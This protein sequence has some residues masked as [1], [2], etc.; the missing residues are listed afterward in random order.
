MSYQPADGVPQQ[1]GWGWYCDKDRHTLQS[2]LRETPGRGTPAGTRI[3]TS[4]DL[5]TATGKCFK[6][7]F[8]ASQYLIAFKSVALT[9]CRL[10]KLHTFLL[11]LYLW[12]DMQCDVTSLPYHLS[13]RPT[14]TGAED[15]LFTAGVAML[16][17]LG[18]KLLGQSEGFAL[19]H[20]LEV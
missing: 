13:L 7:L 19:K 8:K 5:R 4:T 16:L 20:L 2:V 14:L 15:I 10:F 11:P 12:H 3:Y 9:D 18:F 1:K 6:V 17:V